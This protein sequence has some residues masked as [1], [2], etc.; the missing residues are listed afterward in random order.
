MKSQCSCS[1]EGNC[2]LL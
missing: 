2:A 1:F